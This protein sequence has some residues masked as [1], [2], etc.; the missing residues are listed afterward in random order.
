MNPPVTPLTLT[1]DDHS[2][3]RSDHPATL[4]MRFPVDEG[5]DEEV[6]VG[7]YRNRRS[8]TLV[9]QVAAFA[10][11]CSDMTLTLLHRSVSVCQL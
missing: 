6:E 4:H 10:V 8:S 2:Q 11:F 9:S 3:T 5:D 1:I 7:D